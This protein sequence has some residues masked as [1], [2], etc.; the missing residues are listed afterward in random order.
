MSPHA[1][2]HRAGEEWVVGTRHPA[3]EADARIVIE[4]Q[5]KL[6]SAERPWLEDFTRP[7]MPCLAAIAEKDDLVGRNFGVCEASF[8]ANA[9][10][11]CGETEIVFLTPALGRMMMTLSTLDADSEKGL[12]D[13]FDIFRGLPHGAIPQRWWVLILA[14]TRRDDLRD[15]L[16]VRLVIGK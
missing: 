10:K 13:R 14:A 15:E 5:G 3:R 9:S 11:V 8:S 1:I 4:T 6:R 7:W 12:R 2:G 16:I